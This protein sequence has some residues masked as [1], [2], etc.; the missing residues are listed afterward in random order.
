MVQTIAE[1]AVV[2]RQD[3]NEG[4]HAFARVDKTETPS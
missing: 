3:L 1:D 4:N 2:K